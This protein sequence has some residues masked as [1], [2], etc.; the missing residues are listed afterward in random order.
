MNRWTPAFP[1]LNQLERAG[2]AAGTIYYSK[3]ASKGGVCGHQCRARI[4]EPRMPEDVTLH[5]ETDASTDKA[6]RA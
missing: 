3:Q 5:V 6:V 1:T 4:L 2:A